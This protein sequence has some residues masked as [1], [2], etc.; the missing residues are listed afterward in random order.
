M[1]EKD[2]RADTS[3]QALPQKGP[4]PTRQGA[5]AGQRRGPGAGQ[6]KGSRPAQQSPAPAVV[7]VRPSAG[8]AR[9]KGHHWGLLASFSL[10]VLLPLAITVFYL[11]AI[12]EDQYS[13]TTGF[14]VRSEE[15]GAASDLMG[16]L[17]QF[18]GGNTSVDSDVLYEFIQSQE[19]VEAIDDQLELRSY[20]ATHWEQ[21]PVFSLWPDASIEDL[22]WFWQRVV[23]ISYDPG[24][25]LIELRVLAFD[26]E[27]ARNLAQAILDESQS[28]INAL[29]RQAREDAMRYARADLDSAVER[30]K[31]SREALTRFRTRTQIVDPQSD[32]QGRMGVL[33][34]LQQQLA[35]AMI[36]HDLLL[37]A[38]T[39][40]EDPRI[41]QAKRRIQVI[42][43]R[44][45]AERRTFASDSTEVG[46]VGEDY[47][48]LIA[49]FEG[50]TVDREVAEETYRAALKALE[51]ARDNASRQSRYLATYVRPT[52]ADSSEY[53][54]RY[55]LSG[56]AGLF[57]LLTW[58]VFALV[59]YSVRDRS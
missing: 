27:M 37:E 46:D 29:N 38:S 30:L 12:A 59:F 24:P 49:E 8:P 21:D 45:S 34:N 20:Y 32:I 40:P 52:L 26:P 44:I 1:S 5:V 57:L 56:L 4:G 3:Q 19:I 39:N 28:M 22:V 33:N 10:C 16:G 36:E 23:R 6:K 53:P 54:Q 43:E 17:A 11:F 9:M 50:L 58:S 7:E 48:T 51:V 55:V 13:S 41:V 18:A 25:G 31:Q 14:T 35:E 42:R 47:P 2:A 15:S